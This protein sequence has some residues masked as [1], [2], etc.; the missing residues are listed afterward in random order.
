MEMPVVMQV[1][2]T[3]FPYGMVGCIP[4]APKAII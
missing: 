4:E 3:G 2:K 1:A